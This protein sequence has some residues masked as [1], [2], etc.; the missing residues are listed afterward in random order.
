MKNKNKESD[1]KTP[2]T[3]G[4]LGR[5]VI[6]FICLFLVGCSVAPEDV[7]IAEEKCKG[8]DG[9]SSLR[10]ADTGLRIVVTC[11]NGARFE[12]KR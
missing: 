10:L 8:N 12:I 2:T 6:F 9:W 5:V 1:L 4:R 3:A 11:N 7:V